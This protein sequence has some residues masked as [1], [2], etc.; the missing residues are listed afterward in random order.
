ML[1]NKDPSRHEYKLGIKE[2]GE[3]AGGVGGGG[4]GEGLR[5]MPR[6]IILVVQ[7]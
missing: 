6:H 2:G 1:D 4:G 7:S 5:E 3:G